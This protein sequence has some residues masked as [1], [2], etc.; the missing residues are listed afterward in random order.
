MFACRMKKEKEAPLSNDKP[1]C[2]KQEDS[3]SP[4]LRSACSSQALLSLC[5][6]IIS[7]V[8]CPRRIFSALL[9]K[10][11]KIK[12]NIKYF[13][14]CQSTLKKLSPLILIV[15]S[16]LVVMRRRLSR[17]NEGLPVGLQPPT[18]WSEPPLSSA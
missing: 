3:S 13:K 2:F 6:R 7:F 15:P 14:L 8:Q 12:Q 9:D 18:H 16:F 11:M 1:N 5:D 4:R 17:W 10:S